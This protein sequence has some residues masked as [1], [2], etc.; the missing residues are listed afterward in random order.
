[1]KNTVNFSIK[2]PHLT[3]TVHR[4]LS[5]RLVCWKEPIWQV[6]HFYVFYVHKKNPLKG[7][8]LMFVFLCI[9]LETMLPS[10]RSCQRIGPDTSNLAQSFLIEWSFNYQKLQGVWNRGISDQSE[11]TMCLRYA[12]IDNFTLFV[13][14]RAIDA[15]SLPSLWVI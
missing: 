10:P 5:D 11:S 14:C 1:M 2:K 3:S 6:I 13:V 9:F 15:F 4:L 8:F 12:Q 7:L